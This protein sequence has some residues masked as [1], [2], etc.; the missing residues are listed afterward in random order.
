MTVETPDV[1]DASP[2]TD[3]VRVKDAGEGVKQVKNPFEADFLPSYSQEEWESALGRSKA[4]QD[5]QAIKSAGNATKLI[6]RAKSFVGTPYKWGGT[7]PLGFDCSGFTQY[8]Y[9]EL[10][11][12]LPRVSYQQGTY[13]KRVGLDQLKPGDLV[14]WD[15]SSRNNGADHVA[16]YIGDGKVIHAPKPGD[17]VKISSIWDAG[18]A[19]GVAM[20]L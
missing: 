16:I 2:T 3:A 5:P 6:E 13:G 11:I 1:S 17:K 12:N 7:G 18:H 19:W 8:L 9:K 20:N 10:G 14:L 4:T 15:N